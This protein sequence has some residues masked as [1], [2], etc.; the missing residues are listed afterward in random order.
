[1]SGLPL[2]AG[3]P[4]TFK[5]YPAPAVREVRDPDGELLGVQLDL[6]RPAKKLGMPLPPGRPC[7]CQSDA[8]TWSRHFVS[9]GRVG[10]GHAEWAVQH[11]CEDHVV[12]YEFYD[13]G[14]RYHG[15]ECG[16]CRAFVQ[17]G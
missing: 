9:P 2:P 14:R 1:M 7:T 11:S 4:L 13:D 15:W 12:P 10:C 6:G 3:L 16:L 8:L 17:S 5:A